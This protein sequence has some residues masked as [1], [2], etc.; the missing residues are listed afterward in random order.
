MSIRVDDALGQLREVLVGGAFFVERM[1]ERVGIF[2]A[3]ERGSIRSS[4]AVCGDL[5]VLDALGSRDEGRIQH[6]RIAIFLQDFFTLLQHA[7]HSF[8]RL[9]IDVLPESLPDPHV[10]R[11]ASRQPKTSARGRY[12]RMNYALGIPWPRFPADYPLR[13]LGAA[14]AAANSAASST[15]TTSI[16]TARITVHQ[17]TPTR[18]GITIQ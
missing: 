6:V 14:N 16:A 18:S 1:L 17:L 8:A 5:I 2:V 11:R 13:V 7:F 15:T 9:A 12:D 10:D 4:A 3:A